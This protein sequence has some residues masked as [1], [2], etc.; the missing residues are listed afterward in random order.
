MVSKEKLEFI[1]DKLKKKRENR[2]ECVIDYFNNLKPFN[3]EDDI[4]DIPITDESTFKSIIIP[5]LIRCGAIP[6]N[7][8]KINSTYIGSCRNASE[9]IWDGNKFTYKRTKFGC[10][11]D[12]DINHFE[13]DNGYDLFVPIKEKS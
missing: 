11:Y 7:K 6:K 4:P 9:A 10:T 13:D 5:N 1:K 2:K 8:L 3:S 12:E